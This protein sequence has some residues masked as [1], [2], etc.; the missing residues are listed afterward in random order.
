MIEYKPKV[1]IHPGRMIQDN[2]DFLGVSQKWLAEKTGLTE[3]HISEILNEKAPV[4]AETAVRLANTLGGSVEFW[5]N[6]DANYRARRAILE[7]EERAGTE[8]GM[9]SDIPYAEMARKG[10]VPE[11]RN[12]TERV[13]SLYR[14]FGISSLRD[15]RVAEPAAFRDYGGEV[16]QFAL[17]AWLRRG[18]VLSLEV[19]DIPVFNRAVLKDSLR[20]LRDL[21][22]SKNSMQGATEILAECGVILVAVERL[23]GAPV[24]G[25]TRWIGGRP[26]IEMSGKDFWPTLFHEIGHVL[27]HSK[28]GEFVELSRRFYAGDDSLEREAEDF[29]SGIL[30]RGEATVGAPKVVAAPAEVWAG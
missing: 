17:A 1:A 13:L 26:V 12:K 6:L 22:F 8:T 20:R 16:N 29:A 19:S 23:H 9:L 28:K 24:N 21:E 11:A 5:V 3:K 18:E 7:Q 30:A 10:W 15:I 25:A 4:T 14:F 2:L 27:L